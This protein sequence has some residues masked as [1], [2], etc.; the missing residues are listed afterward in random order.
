MQD[1]FVFILKCLAPTLTVWAVVLHIKEVLQ[2]MA[3]HRQLLAIECEIEEIITEPKTPAVSE[4]KNSSTLT[5]GCA[6]EFTENGF[7]TN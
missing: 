1:F 2:E 6:V 4:R 3:E 7:S 5:I